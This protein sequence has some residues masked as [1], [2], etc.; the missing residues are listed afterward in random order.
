MF[1][2]KKIKEKRIEYKLCIIIIINNE[3]RYKRDLRECS[4]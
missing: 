4:E 1:S 3:Y 2:I